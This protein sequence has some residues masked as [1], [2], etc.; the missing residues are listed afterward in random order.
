M[1]ESHHACRLFL[2]SGVSHFLRTEPIFHTKPMQINVQ[3]EPRPHWTLQINVQCEPRPQPRMMPQNRVVDTLFVSSIEILRP[4][5]GKGSNNVCDLILRRVCL[6]WKFPHPNYRFRMKL[7]I[8]L[9]VLCILFLRLPPEWSGC[10]R[11]LVQCVRRL[12]IDDAHEPSAT[13]SFHRCPAL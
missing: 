11:I 4:N 13:V 7:L 6:V 3:C 12:R 10:W 2:F 1:K 8:Q 9:G 5:S